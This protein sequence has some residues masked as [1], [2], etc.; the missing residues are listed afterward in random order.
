[1]GCDIHLYSE[2]RQNGG[3][4][5][6]NQAD[7]VVREKEDYGDG[8]QE[9][10]R[11]DDMREYSG[12]DYWLFGM[13][14]NGVRTSWDWAFPYRDEFPAESSELLAELKKQEGEDAH[15]CSYFTVAELKGKVAELKL[16]RAEF[17]IN[18]PEQGQWA[19]A[20]PYHADKLQALIDQF[21]PTLPDKDQR[22]VFWF[23]N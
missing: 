17:L 18:P 7:S 11:M 10:L 9:Y 6:C 5:V 13:L 19:E 4:W 15:S 2:T 3:A 23:D 14:N 20:L 12:R 22:I 21:D 8:E 1:M 16:K